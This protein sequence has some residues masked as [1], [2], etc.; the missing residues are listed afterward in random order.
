MQ[1]ETHSRAPVLCRRLKECGENDSYER[2]ILSHDNGP[3]DHGSS[4]DCSAGRRRDSCVG[5]DCKGGGSAFSRGCDGRVR[6]CVQDR[7]LER[8][9]SLATASPLAKC[10]L[11]IEIS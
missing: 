6:L 10:Q 2:E 11:W 7:Y 3:T 4:L 9:A 8:S 1:L 5:K